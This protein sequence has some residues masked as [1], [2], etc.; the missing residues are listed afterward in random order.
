[1]FGPIFEVYD[2]KLIVTE[3]E[4]TIKVYGLPEAVDMEQGIVT[5]KSLENMK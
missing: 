5:G 4:G 3:A 2:I 1:M